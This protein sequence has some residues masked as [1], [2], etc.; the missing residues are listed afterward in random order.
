MRSKT[1]LLIAGA[2]A[3]V[4]AAG[5]GVAL[6]TS[7]TSSAPTSHHT[8][9]KGPEPTKSGVPAS[10]EESFFTEA[11]IGRLASLLRISSEQAHQVAQ[12]LEQLAASAN[13]LSPSDPEFVAIAASVGKTAAELRTAVSTLKQMG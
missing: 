6:A 1:W 2:A 7:A 12:R 11:R 13:G 5:S 3:T 8:G 10:H 9:P 4:I